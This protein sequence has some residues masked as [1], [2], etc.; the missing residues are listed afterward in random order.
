[1]KIKLIISENNVGIR[2][3][4]KHIISPILTSLKI[5]PKFGMFHSS[6]MVGPWLL[7]WNESGLCVPRMLVSRAAFFTADL[8]E[9]SEK[10]VSEVRDKVA[11]V[12]TR[13]NGSMN[14]TMTKKKN[15][16]G[17]CQDFIIDLLN[18]L[19]IKINFEGSLGKFL[20]KIRLDGKSEM[21]FPVSSKLRSELEIPYQSVMFNTHQE[22][23]EFVMMLIGSETNFSV[24]YKDD[25]ELLKSFDRA[26]WLRYFKIVKSKN[27]KEGNDDVNSWKPCTKCPFGNPE[28][29]NFNF[30]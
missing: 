3:N 30:L 24:L 5:S 23:D 27:Y 22:L 11:D 10:C 26:F 1:M 4:A 12:I 2:K 17:N 16:E 18:A 19:E 7:D 20:E 21:E 13:W 9:I 25:W 28:G 14:Y 8:M 29:N 15:N 6:L